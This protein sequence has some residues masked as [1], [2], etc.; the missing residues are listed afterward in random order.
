MCLWSD[1]NNITDT[2]ATA[3]ASALTQNQHLQGLHLGKDYT[4]YS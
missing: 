3:L 4:L 2:G 1:G